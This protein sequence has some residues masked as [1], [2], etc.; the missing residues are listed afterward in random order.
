MFI[1]YIQLDFFNINFLESEK[2]AI[3]NQILE[4]F[5]D[6]SILLS[7]IEPVILHLLKKQ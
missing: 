4:S 3:N 6:E 7:I 1:K 5:F 2:M